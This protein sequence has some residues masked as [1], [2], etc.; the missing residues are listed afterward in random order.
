MYIDSVI[1][2][3]NNKR[4][5]SDVYIS[6]EKGEIIGLFGRNGSGKSTLLKIIFS[7]IKAD[8]KFLR[9]NNHI[10]KNVIQ[11]KDNIAYLSENSFI[12]NHINIETIINIFCEK[13]NLSSLKSTPF[14]IPI[15]KKKSDEISGGERR[16]VEILIILNS[17][18]NYILLDEPFKGLSPIYVDYIKNLIKKTSTYKGIIITDH[19]YK[20]VLEITSRNLLLH[21][22]C[23]LSLNSVSELK[24]W[25]YVN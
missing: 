17:K 1:K 11:S 2:Y 10:I 16:M 22:G 6:C 12:P 9:I 23:L 3:Y 19:D 20:N 24:F 13:R 18:A 15:L 25:G 8:Q 5:L 14:I 4:I 7:S 21:E